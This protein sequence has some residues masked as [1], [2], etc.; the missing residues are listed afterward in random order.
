[1]NEASVPVQPSGEPIDSVRGRPAPAICPV[2]HQPVR[3]EFYFCPNCG[4]DLKEKPV[5]VSAGAQTSLYL[6]SIV[7]PL[8][9]FLTIRWWKGM[10]YLRSSNPQARLIGFVA[11][12]LMA[13][14]TI[15]LTWQLAVFT[16][17]LMSSLTGGLL[18]GTGSL[19]F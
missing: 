9:C 8:L 1:M 11:A 6:M 13:V 5:S 18:G 17:Q 3:P 10:R 14:T 2:C 12:V 15:V 19:G 4:K 16:S 7:T